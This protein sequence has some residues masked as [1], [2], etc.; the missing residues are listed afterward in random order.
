MLAAKAPWIATSS[1]ALRL[2]LGDGFRRAV[3]AMSAQQGSGKEEIR[4]P[5]WTPLRAAE[6]RVEIRS[7][8]SVRECG[9]ERGYRRVLDSAYGQWLDIPLARAEMIV[10]LDYP[11]WLSLAR[12][13]RRTVRRVIGRDVVCNGNRESLRLVLS[14]NSIIVWHFRSFTRKQRRMREWRADPD[15]PPVLLFRSPRAARTWLQQLD[16]ASPPSKGASRDLPSLGRSPGWSCR[17]PSPALAGR[18]DRCEFG[19]G[20]RL[21]R[22]RK[23]VGG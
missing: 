6:T 7:V 18:Q 14:R 9:S 21:S 16:E 20:R 3:Q 8:T 1:H 22:L 10:G 4:R 12:L 13:I 5:R 19:C 11:R 17:T 2:P 15:L 23:S